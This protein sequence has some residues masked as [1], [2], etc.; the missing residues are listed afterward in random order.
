MDINDLIDDYVNEIKNSEEF[1]ELIGL[2]DII[3]SKYKDLIIKFKTCESLYLEAKERNYLDNSI[4]KNF[5]EAKRNLYSK[6]EVK[7]YFEL[8]SKLNL[9]LNNDFNEIKENISN[10]FSLNNWPF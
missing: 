4:I 2:R 7:K 3:D 1:K 6:D 8:E 9:K 5:S 10:K